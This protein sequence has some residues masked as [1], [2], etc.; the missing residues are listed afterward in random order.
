MCF[1]FSLQKSFECNITENE[2]FSI[3][4]CSFCFASS[5]DILQTMKCWIRVRRDKEGRNQREI[6]KERG[7][8]EEDK[9]KRRMSA[10]GKDLI[11]KPKNGRRAGTKKGDLL[12]WK[13]G[14]QDDNSAM[15]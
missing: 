14:H 8:R 12:N 2:G 11:F 10:G 7:K 15:N 6:E 4:L 9:R 3:V 13:E 1:V 5:K